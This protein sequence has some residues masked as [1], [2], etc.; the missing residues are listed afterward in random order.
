MK[1]DT[2]DS[3]ARSYGVSVQETAELN[4]IE[5]SDG[6]EVGA[7]I[8]IPEKHKRGGFKKLPFGKYL[9]SEKNER[10]SGKKMFKRELEKYE[11]DNIRVDHG[12]FSWP[13]DGKIT[14]LFG[15][16]NGRRHDGIDLSAKTGTPIK[17]AGPG[18]VV[19]SGRMKGYGN[20]IIIRH[21]DDF[22]TV[23]AHNDKN[24]VGKGDNVKDRQTI[25]TVGRTGRATGPHLHFEVRHGQK[26][27]NP[28]FFLPHKSSSEFARK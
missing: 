2:L 12:R 6:V 14:S 4:N 24:K 3:I 8:Y 26:A 23:Y 1:G 13:V 21:R 10:A 17:A 7:K 28:L 27:R 19:F 15:I 16:R 11:D 18:K 9:T 22:F 25:A 5:R 20:L